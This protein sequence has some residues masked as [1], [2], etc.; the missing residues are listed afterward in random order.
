MSFTDDGMGGGLPSMSADGGAGGLFLELPDELSTQEFLRPQLTSRREKGWGERL[1]YETGVCFLTGLFGG[2]SV[3]A[4]QGFVASRQMT[5]TKLKLNS[6]LN[7]SGRMGSRLG[8]G[9]AVFAMLFSLSKTMIKD[10]RRKNDVY[11]DV[12]AVA[13]AGLLTSIPKGPLPAVGVGMAL[14][15]AATIMVWTR[16][17]LT[18]EL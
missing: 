7:H 5:H 18:G 10:Q 3:G 15:S 4:V 2:G 17:K 12:A 16:M 11:N 14:G 13:A 6:I 9:F 8:N 1:T